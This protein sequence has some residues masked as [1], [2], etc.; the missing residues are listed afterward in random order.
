MRIE[1]TKPLEFEGATV[2]H[3]DLDLE[4]LTGKDLLAAEREAMSL[5]SGP[6]TDISKTYAACVAAKA[7]KVVV[8]LLLALP[9]KDFTRVT[10]EVQGF[11]LLA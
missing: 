7:A 3:L 5:S 8:D 1:L 10:A 6:V 2:D 4:A 9:A 11:L